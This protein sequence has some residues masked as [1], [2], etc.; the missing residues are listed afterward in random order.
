M[1]IL[2]KYKLPNE[3]R[4]AKK[5]L[6]ENLK[7]D[8]L[9]IYEDILQRFPRNQNAIKGINELKGDNFGQNLLIKDPKNELTQIVVNFYNSGHFKEALKKSLILLKD[10]PKSVILLN[11]AGAC[12]KALKN[13]DKAEATFKE[14]LKLKPDA[15]AVYNN[16]GTVLLEKEQFE[17][18]KLFVGL[19]LNLLFAVF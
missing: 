15:A 16:L 14:A 17:D 4:L 2:D 11:I 19:A 6:K 7:N 10:F 8:A 5:K 13:L 12:Y 1:S 9:K 18:F 3:L